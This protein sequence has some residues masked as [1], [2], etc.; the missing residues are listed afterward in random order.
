MSFENAP[1]SVGTYGDV[2]EMPR[3]FRLKRVGMVITAC[4]GLE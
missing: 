2:I 4:L 3:K 1:C